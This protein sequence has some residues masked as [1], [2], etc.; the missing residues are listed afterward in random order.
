MDSILA[1]LTEQTCGEACW[2]AKEDICRCSCGGSNHGCL[3][4]ASGAQPVRSA[5][6]D[7]YM[8]QLQGVGADDLDKIGDNMNK[9]SGLYIRNY[10][11]DSINYSYNSA[12]SRDKMYRGSPAKARYATES[13]I[14]KW[15]ELS[16]WRG[17][18]RYQNP[19]TLLWVRAA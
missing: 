7:G 2:H 19:C 10:G 13:Q 15:P 18:D 16:Q 4:D 12:R 5:K 8:Y 14:E 11:S 9:D 6:I 3:R 17:K 1:Y